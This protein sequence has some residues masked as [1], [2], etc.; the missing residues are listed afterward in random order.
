MTDKESS[1]QKRG[2]EL[3][4]DSSLNKSTAFS[5]EERKTLGL[6]GL[7]PEITET[8]EIQQQRVMA[9]LGHKSTDLERYIFLMNLFDND[10]D[11][12]LSNDHV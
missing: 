3:L 9:Q 10:S 8:A 7:L 1:N 4:N 11:T 5:E 2:I 6:I 12:L